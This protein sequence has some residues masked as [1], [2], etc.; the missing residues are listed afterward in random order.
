[1]TKNLA[2][3]IGIASY[4][5]RDELIEVFFPQPEINPSQ[6]RQ[7][8]VEQILGA[9][10]GTQTTT[11]QLDTNQLD[12]L[13]AAFPTAARFTAQTLSSRSRSV[14][15][16]VTDLTQ[17]PESVADSFLRLHL[18]SHRIVRP[19]SINLDGI[20]GCLKNLAWTNEGPIDLEELPERLLRGRLDGQPVQVYLID[21]FPKMVDYVVPSGVRIG[22]GARIRLGAYLGSGTTVMHEGFVNFN[23]GC[24]GPNMIEGR[25]SA[26]VFVERDSDLGGG[27]STM[28]TLSGGNNQVISV[29]RNCLIGANSGIGIPLGDNCT[30]EAGL[31]VT[32]TSKVTDRSTGK[33]DDAPVVKAAS[34]AGKS[35]LLFRRNSVSGAIECLAN[36]TSAMLNQA[37][38]AND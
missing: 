17:A 19:H 9:K 25:V 27:C 32:G 15:L 10:I 14:V 8:L 35:N 31:Y 29:G 30:I 36:K 2:V 12:R 37:L 38:H 11:V 33:N 4:N 5:S 13:A 6:D 26:G 22:D 20:F 24:A 21:K 7:T 1:M 18:L 34:L 28:G 23:A 3:A 16:T